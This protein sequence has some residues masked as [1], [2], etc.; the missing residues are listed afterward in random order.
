MT[1]LL[2]RYHI[3]QLYLVCN[4]LIYQFKI[5][6]EFCQ[7]AKSRLRVQL[8]PDGIVLNTNGDLQQLDSLVAPASLVVPVGHVLQVLKEPLL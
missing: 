8:L 3:P 7:F 1:A 6:S 5:G 2:L 4:H